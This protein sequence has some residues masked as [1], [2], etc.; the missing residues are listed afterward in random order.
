MGCARDIVEHVGVPRFFYSEFPLGHSAGKPHDEN[1]Q[2]Q[3]LAGALR[4]FATTTHPRTTMKSD[5]IWS[6]DDSWEKDFLNIQRLSEKEIEK[7]REDYKQQRA[8][9]AKLKNLSND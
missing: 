3:T 9:T 2:R 8:K 6:Q 7:L 5:Q 4:L 1:S